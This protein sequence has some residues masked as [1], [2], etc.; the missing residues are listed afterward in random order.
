MGV[1]ATPSRS[2]SAG[3]LLGG[4]GG[5]WHNWVSLAEQGRHDSFPSSQEL[6]SSTTY[7]WWS[8][9]KI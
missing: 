6:V 8:L 2:A 3:G 1:W 9:G 7:K 4:G 5:L